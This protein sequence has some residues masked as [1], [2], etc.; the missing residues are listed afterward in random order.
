MADNRDLEHRQPD[1]NDPE[2]RFEH[3]DVNIWAIGKVGIGLILTTI[4]SLV[5]VLGVFRYLEVQENARQV[6]ANVNAQKLPPEPRLLEN[7]PANLQ[8]FRATEDQ[9][10]NGYSWVDQSKGIVKIPID[11]AIDRLVQKGIPAR[12]ESPPPSDVSVPTA[13]GLG[14][15]VQQPGGPLASPAAAGTKK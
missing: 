12:P 11:K 2:Q 14:P 1:L 15:K 10:V 13:S 3:Q 7:E 8:Q 5:L 6:P 4:A 9:T